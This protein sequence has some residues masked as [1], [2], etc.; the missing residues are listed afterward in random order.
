MAFLFPQGWF[1]YEF[2]LDR[3]YV[4]QDT[5]KVIRLPYPIKLGTF[6]PLIIQR[7]RS[8]EMKYVTDISKQ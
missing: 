4:S 3:L 5:I 8:M 7:R 1:I 6:V 2:R